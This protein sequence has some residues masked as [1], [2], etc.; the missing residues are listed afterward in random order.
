MRIARLGCPG[1]EIPVVPD[2]DRVLDLRAV[3]PEFL[4][5][6]L[7]TLDVI[8]LPELPDAEG[9]RFGPPVTRPIAEPA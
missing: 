4:E 5:H 9:L 3:T 6:G 8:A 1:Q 2:G 7:P